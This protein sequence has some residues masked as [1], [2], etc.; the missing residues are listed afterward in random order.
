MI[1]DEDTRLTKL[2]VGGIPYDT[3]NDSLRGFFIKF[4]KIKEAV[5]IRDRDTLK[6]KGYGFVTFFDKDC[7]EKACENRRPVI[8]GRTANVNLAYIGAKP[9]PNK[10]NGKYAMTA[11]GLGYRHNA[12]MSS[13]PFPGNFPAGFSQTIQANQQVQPV[14]ALVTPVP[15]SPNGQ[16]PVSLP[17]AVQ[18]VQLID[19]NG[20]PT[21]VFGAMYDQFV[22]TL[23]TSYVPSPT[24]PASSVA[25]TFT[26]QT[27]APQTPPF[28]PLNG[29]QFFPPPVEII[30]Q[31]Q[32]I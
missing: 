20:I 1:R 15:Q 7:A 13:Q 14:P 9:K 3:D 8:D 16:I 30:G 32:P 12:I 18:P 6:S 27:V 28:S 17:P 22:F 11:N 26:Y 25:T 31:P 19:Y 23:P 5:V 2:F 21:L 24:P 10:G 4:G 29:Q